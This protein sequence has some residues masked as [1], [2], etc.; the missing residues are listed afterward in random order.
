[1]QCPDDHFCLILSAQEHLQHMLKNLV[2]ENYALIRELN[3]SF[4]AGLTIITGET[5]AGKSIMLGAL[6]LILGKRADTSV[7]YDKGKKC[8]VEGLFD[9]SPYS[10]KPF[11]LEND[12]D[13]E[14]HVLIR[15]EIAASGKSR[16]F[17]NDL[18]VTLEVL[19][20][21][22]D[23]L[24]DIH[25]Q[26]QHLN[27]ND[28]GFQLKVVDSYAGTME[29]RAKYRTEYESFKALQQQLNQLK[30]E[31]DKSKADLDYF[32]FQAGQLR[33]AALSE[34]EQEDLEQEL[35]KLTHAEEI[36]ASLLSA[37]TLL[38]GESNSLLANLK[39]TMDQLVRAG[40]YLPLSG[41]I[42]KRCE[43]SYIDLK[44]AAAEIENQY[45]KIDHDPERMDRVKNRLDLLYGLQQKHRKASVK[46]LMELQQ[47]LENKIRTIT[48]YDSSLEETAARLDAKRKALQQLAEKLSRRRRD[49]FSSIEGQVV[50]MLHELGIPGASFSIKHTGLPDFSPSGT[51][52]VQFMFSANKN[53]TPQDISKVASGG[54]LSRLMLT[55]KSLLSEAT[56]LPTIVFD[57]ID[58]GVSGEVAE[59][60]GNII[61]RMAGKMQLINITHLPQIASKGEI[62][63]LVYKSESD[64]STVTKIKTLTPEERHLEIARML[65]GEEITAAALEN[66][67][68][69]LK[70]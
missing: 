41:E 62:H 40:K 53:V 5:G 29:L 18:P 27:L 36:K 49:S 70:N 39:E 24:I 55:V 9:I 15:R 66:A 42:A 19:T 14:D 23:Q 2:I 38:A 69:L 28:Y 34:G 67:R 63:L 30:E 37:M 52:Q 58:T 1:M 12:L 57:E 17:V 26:H 48:G 3:I 56:G 61:K 54:E 64:Q 59:K 31:A 68:E 16:A 13:Y 22:S 44:D 7:L 43:I 33:E 21:L 50:A 45:E 35:E 10:L 46:E 51:D 4:G 25:S 20:E 65:S 32:T 6:G 60:V 47:E 8:I 11:F